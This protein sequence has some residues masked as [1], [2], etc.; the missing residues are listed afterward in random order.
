MRGFIA[1]NLEGFLQ[2]DDKKDHARKYRPFLA[3]SAV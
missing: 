3:W 2:K 1:Q